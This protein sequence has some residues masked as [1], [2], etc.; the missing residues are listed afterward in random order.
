MNNEQ[1]I[2]H[3]WVDNAAKFGLGERTYDSGH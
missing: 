1:E 2:H 3:S